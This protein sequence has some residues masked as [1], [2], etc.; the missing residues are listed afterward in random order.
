MMS[1][2][3][4]CFGIMIY[5]TLGELWAFEQLEG[6]CW[7]YPTKATIQSVMSYLLIILL[8]I[9]ITFFCNIMPAFTALGK[10]F[11]SLNQYFP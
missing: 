10:E 11:F 5:Q 9:R 6:S 7:G 1:N 8:F 2:S 4:Y 3:A